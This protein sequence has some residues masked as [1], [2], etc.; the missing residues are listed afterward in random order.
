MKNTG[1]YVNIF[2]A[3]FYINIYKVQ[4]VAWSDIC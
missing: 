2:P 1:L 3:L 4:I